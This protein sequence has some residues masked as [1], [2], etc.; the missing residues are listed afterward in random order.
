MNNTYTIV[1][2]KN[3]R[4]FSVDLLQMLEMNITIAF[5]A[6]PLLTVILALVGKMIYQHWKNHIVGDAAEFGDW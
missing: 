5:P 4:C 3:S 2:Y 6:A 1:L